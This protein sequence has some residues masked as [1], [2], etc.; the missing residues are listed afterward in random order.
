MEESR[1]RGVTSRATSVRVLGHLEVEIV[2]ARDQNLDD[3]DVELVVAR[4]AT[5]RSDDS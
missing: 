3:D 1:R 5:L 2:T 4:T